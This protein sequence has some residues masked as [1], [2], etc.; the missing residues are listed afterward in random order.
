MLSLKNRLY[1]ILER[2][3]L[4]T[5]PLYEGDRTVKTQERFIIA[6]HPE[7][8]QVLINGSRGSLIRLTDDEKEKLSSDAS[9]VIRTPSNGY[10]LASYDISSK[11]NYNCVH[12]YLGDE[13]QVAQEMS[14]A[15]CLKMID[16]IE[17]TGVLWLQFS[18]GEPLLS[19]SFD[20]AYRR[21]WQSGMIVSIQTNGV[22]LGEDRYV[23]LFG[24]YRPANISVSLYGATQKTYESVTR[25][26]GAWSRFV[27]S[28][29]TALAHH[30]PINMLV[31]KM[32]QNEHELNQM[33][34]FAS[35]FERMG[36]LDFITPAMGARTGRESRC[37]VR[38]SPGSSWK[39]CGAGRRTFHVTSQ[40][41]LCVCKMAHAPSVDADSLNRL[42]VISGNLLKLPKTCRIC[43]LYDQCGICPPVYR[44]L[45]GANQLPEERCYGEGNGD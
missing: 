14:L 27:S 19:K 45:H 10:V 9:C 15:G 17:H 40:G 32:I 43:K 29:E 13:R 4:N 22:L 28:M 44:V 2:C 37:S 6:T 26:K 25:C 7:L 1:I 21:A 30:L 8:G 11:C 33:I 36:V 23:K 20:A 12:C 31:V 35:R 39:D 42:P 3:S 24:K 18:G 16:A 38:K 41:R 34:D 5:S